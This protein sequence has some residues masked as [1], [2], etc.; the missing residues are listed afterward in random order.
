MPEKHTSP[1]QTQEKKT[2]VIPA[3]SI[4]LQDLS[5]ADIEQVK[6]E[7]K[8]TLSPI[9]QHIDE[10]AH[11]VRFR[12]IQVLDELHAPR[13]LLYI[14]VAE[15][16]YN[17]Y[18]LSPAGAFGLWQ[19]MPKTAKELGA[20]D[21]NGLDGRRHIESSTKAAATYLLS[22]YERFNSWPLAICAYNLGPWGVQRRLNK[23]PWSPAMGLDA[24][25]FPGE[26]KHY[27]KQILGM[28]ALEQDGELQFSE[29]LATQDIHI[30]AP[31]DLNQMEKVSGL[32]KYEIFRLNP[33]FDYQ[34]YIHHDVVVH[35]PKENAV[36]LEQ[37]LLNNPNIFKPKYI[38]I[39]IKSG[40]S[41]WKLAKRYHTSIKQLQQLNPKL[42]GVLSIGKSMTVPAS[43]N[44]FASSSKANPLLAK[45]RRI[46]YKV[47]SGDSL[48]TI[49]KKFG[50][51]T[52][53]ITRINQ[54][55]ANQLLRPGDRLWIVARYR[56]S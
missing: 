46:R 3:P 29:A 26:T 9:W 11:R 52:R 42:K 45:G 10:R 55:S 41:L 31:I 51:S 48:W 40:D 13:E 7:A 18:A 22:L 21:K 23:K 5:P 14:P 4:F 35:L 34:H 33:A 32:A 25:P 30:P 19:L 24:L 39:K 20:R 47:R 17:P 28:I 50:T 1:P 49:A 43:G 36:R 27:V 38:T 44:I 15:S 53:A 2:V 6:A 16:G 56:P 37:A 12:V 54:M 8:R